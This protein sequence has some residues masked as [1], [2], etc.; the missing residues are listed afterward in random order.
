V[1]QLS[2]A[3]EGINGLDNGL[4]SSVV[5]VKMKDMAGRLGRVLISVD[6]SPS[7]GVDRLFWVSDQPKVAVA[8]KGSPQYLPLQGI[9]VLELV[10]HDESK[11]M[12]KRCA[13]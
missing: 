1:A 4:I 3:K 12:S 13:S 8:M 11:P 2:V 9:S 6:V 7:E 5:D 10:N